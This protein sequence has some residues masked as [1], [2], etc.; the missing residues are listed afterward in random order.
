MKK[1]EQGYI[2]A[3]QK[4]Y[5]EFKITSFK[6]NQH[7]QN[8][9]V[10]VINKQW[11]FRFPK[12]DHVLE[13]FCAEVDLL[14]ALQGRLPL[15]I[16]NPV[17]LHLETGAHSF[18][19]YKMIPGEPLWRETYWAIKDKQVI[20]SLVDQLANFL[21]ALHKLP[22]GELLSK[23]LQVDDTY[24]LVNAFYERIQQKLFVFMRPDARH[25]VN[26]HFQ[27]FLGNPG[28]FLYQPVLK[29]SDFGSSNILY[30]KESQRISG[31]ID[32]S[33]SKLGDP[34]YDFAGLLSCYGD[35]FIHHCADYY[36]EI[37]T[38]FERILFYQ[39][40]FALEE[41]LFGFENEDS[42]AFEAGIAQY[43]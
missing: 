40:T 3:I 33:S 34:A 7:G 6:L 2:R 39:G 37:D 30:D 19:G 38:F 43:R 9:D 24:Q 8:S 11:V 13:K 16:P 27:R 28:N 18:I 10:L 35:A 31:I 26:E 17:Y 21:H 41:A 32:F 12:Y 4:I 14:Q 15:P 20:E 42:T 23:P 36:P 1:L 29:H 25:Q 5:P 22:A